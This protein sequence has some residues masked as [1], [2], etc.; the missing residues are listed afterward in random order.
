ML[1]QLVFTKVTQSNQS[2]KIG[3]YLNK[4]SGLMMRRVNFVETSYLYKK[5]CNFTAHVMPRL[6]ALL[7]FIFV[8]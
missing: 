1:K 8:D 2:A 5:Q 7:Q 3:F 6:S 4:I